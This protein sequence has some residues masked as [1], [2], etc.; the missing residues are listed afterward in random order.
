VQTH[1]VKETKV[2]LEN[3]LTFMVYGGEE[4]GDYKSGVIAPRLEWSSKT[5]A[6]VPR[7]KRQQQPVA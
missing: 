6:Y 7:G 3:A 2:V 1:H 4:A 5:Y